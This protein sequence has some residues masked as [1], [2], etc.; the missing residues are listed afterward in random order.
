MR[1]K[2][3]IYILKIVTIIAALIGFVWFVYY[4]SW[5]IELTVISLLIVYILFPIVELLRNH[6]KFSHF[7]AVGVAFLLFLLLIVILISLIVP[8]VQIELRAIIRDLPHYVKQF[9]LLAEELSDYLTSF[10]LNVEFSDI[11]PDLSSNLRTVLE[12]V[13][14]ISITVVA[15]IVDMFFIAFIVFFLLYDFQNIRDNIIKIIPVRYEKYGRDVLQIIDRNFGGYIRGNIVRC[16]IVGIATGIALY[17]AGMPYALFLGIIAGVLNVILYIG[18]YVAAFPAILISVSPNT[19]SI[20]VVILIYLVVQTIDGTVLAP[21]LLGRAVKLKPVTVIICLLI[22]G[23]L[24]GFLGI[25]ISI[26][27]AGIVRSLI[28]YFREGLNVGLKD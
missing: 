4:I 14:N 27:L 8:I 5:V 26:P 15:S 24:A 12:E 20:M 1:D 3:T 11:I 28:E 17:I 13:A 2:D 7:S 23:E 16:T 22:G 18:P 25:I 19:P 10:D 6:L 21:L 9:Q